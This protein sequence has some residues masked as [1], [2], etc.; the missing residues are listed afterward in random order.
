[1]DQRSRGSPQAHIWVVYVVPMKRLPPSLPNRDSVPN[2]TPRPPPH[3]K[4]PD[5]RPSLSN[6][7]P[8]LHHGQALHR[9]SC[10]PVNYPKPA[11]RHCQHGVGPVL[12]LP[13]PGFCFLMP[14]GH[15]APATSMR[16]RCLFIHCIFR[17]TYLEGSNVQKVFASLSHSFS[18]SLHVNGD[19]PNSPVPCVSL[20]K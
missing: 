18:P 15:A 7:P 9:A 3:L 16:C 1:M 8:S 19:S 6:P 12:K 5:W 17:F 20:Y 14:P 13:E 2:N 4:A 11:C 10:S